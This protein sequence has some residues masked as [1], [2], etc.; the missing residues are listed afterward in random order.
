VVR[1]YEDAYVVDTRSDQVAQPQ[2]A[3]VEAQQQAGGVAPAVKVEPPAHPRPAILL[4][5][6]QKADQRHE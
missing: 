5:R 4:R 2:G 3:V 1:R 6:I